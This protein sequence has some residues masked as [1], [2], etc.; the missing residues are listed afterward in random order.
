[1]QIFSRLYQKTLDWAQSQFAIYW[2]SIVSFLESSILPYPPPDIILAPMVLKRPEKA[3]YFALITTL[4]SVLGG[5]V[6]YFLGEILL[7]F[8]LTTE[9]IKPNA[10]YAVKD[11]FDQY[12][13][14]VVGVAAF[15]PIPYKLATITAGSMAMALLPFI[16]ISIL[17]RGARYYL[18]A[19]LVKTYGSQCDQWLQKYIDRLGYGLIVIVIFGAWHVG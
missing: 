9:L 2:L 13:I 16:V 19:S 4:F 6:G 8:L 5:L 7:N 11:F 10:I 15:S 1:M 17:A 14:W 3:Y 12:G 18:V